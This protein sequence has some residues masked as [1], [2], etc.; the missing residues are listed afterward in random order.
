M[1]IP[2]LL[3]YDCS[4]SRKYANCTKLCNNLRLK[5]LEACYLEKFIFFI[6]AQR[7]IVNF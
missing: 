2:E 6:L 5:V 7:I 3:R 4:F 1:W